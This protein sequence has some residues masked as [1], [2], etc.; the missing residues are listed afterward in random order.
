MDDELLSHFDGTENI[1][2]DTIIKEFK[3]SFP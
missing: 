2:F 1:E 3:D